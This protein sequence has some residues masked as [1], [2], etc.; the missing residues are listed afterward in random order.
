ME[1]ATNLDRLPFSSFRFIDFIREYNKRL[2]YGKGVHE[3][4]Y[5]IRQ[6]G[7]MKSNALFDN[8]VIADH[9][10]STNVAD[11][12]DLTDY[13]YFVAQE[14]SSN[15]RFRRHLSIVNIYDGS[16]DTNF[17]CHVLHDA[18]NACKSVAKELDDSH[19]QTESARSEFTPMTTEIIED[20]VIAAY[21]S[22]KIRSDSNMSSKD[23]PSQL[24]LWVDEVRNAFQ[25]SDDLSENDISIE[26]L[27]D[28]EVDRLLEVSLAYEKILLPAFY[29]SPNGASN[30]IREFQQ[31]K[32]CSVDT[33]KVLND[34]KWDILWKS[35]TILSR[36]SRDEP[37]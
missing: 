8:D 7:G 15:P 36:F 37:V 12:T 3:D 19:V 26:C 17:F 18:H 30:L 32:F 23:I 31:W 10:D 24:R 13:T 6:F 34:S 1:H 2:F 20:L 16:I 22:G 11:L 29:D 25:Q 27:Y 5:P 33:E 21:K 28:F 4:G 9:Y 35:T 14:Y